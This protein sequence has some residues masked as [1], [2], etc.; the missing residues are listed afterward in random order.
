MGGPKIPAPSPAEVALQGEQLALT[1]L[2]RQQ[3][4]RALALQNLA[5]PLV[6]RQLGFNATYDERGRITSLTEID[7]E[8]RDPLYRR[9]QEVEERLLDRTLAGLRGELP[10]A[11]GLLTD[12]QR[13]EEMLRE[14]LSRGLGPG[15]ELS[16]PGARRLEEFNLRRNQLLE[17]ARR[18]DITLGE[19]LQLARQFGNEQLYSARNARAVFPYQTF[20][21]MGATFGQSAGQLSSAGLQYYLGSRDLERR[22]LENRAQFMTGVGAMAGKAAAG[23]ATIFFPQLAPFTAALMKL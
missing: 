10:V 22:A 1:R 16:T 14:T 2:Q 11:P 9:R 8:E 6:L 19:Q 21:T 20:G 7:P 3:A 12:L 4:E 13:Q 17:E 5:E 18:G 23:L 15:Y